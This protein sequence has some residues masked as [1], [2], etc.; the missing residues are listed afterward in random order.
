MED[1][2]RKHGVNF[3]RAPPAPKR[4]SELD[5]CL[6][7][8]VEEHLVIE[9]GEVSEVNLVCWNCQ[10]PGHRYQDCLSVRTVFCYGCGKADT[11]KP[12]CRNCQS[13]NQRAS[14][15]RCAHKK[16]SQETEI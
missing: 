5:R 4:I 16:P 1:I 15:Q 13:K 2:R 6:E 11:Y 9:G 14:A 12:N 8:D 3:T 10:K 7:D